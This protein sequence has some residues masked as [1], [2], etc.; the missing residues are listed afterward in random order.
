MNPEERLLTVREVAEYLRLSPRT[1]RLWLQ[2]GKL[3]GLRVGGRWR[4]RESDL[5][6][7]LRAAEEA[8]LRVARA[9]SK[10]GGHGDKN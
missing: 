1:V 7:F 10:G 5:V 9:E 8:V 2:T 4:V 3:R 6:E